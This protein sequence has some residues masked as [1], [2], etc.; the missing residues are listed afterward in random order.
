MVAWPAWPPGSRAGRRLFSPIHF[1]PISNSVSTAIPAKVLADALDHLKQT[2]AALKPYLHA[3]TPDERKSL[4]KMGDESVSFMAKLLD[5]ATNS[6]AF[7]PTFI[8]FTELKQDVGVATA[9]APLEQ[10]AA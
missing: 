4:A 6:P 3:L 8:S 9:L 2:R 7:V 1:L 10:F 5:Y